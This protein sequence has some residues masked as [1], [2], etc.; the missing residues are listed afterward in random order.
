MDAIRSIEE[1]ITSVVLVVTGEE[2]VCWPGTDRKGG[3]FS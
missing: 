2:T 1:H 3:I